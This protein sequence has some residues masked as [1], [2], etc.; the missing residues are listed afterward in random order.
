MWTQA[1]GPTTILLT[2]DNQIFVKNFP[3]FIAKPDP[4]QPPFQGQDWQGDWSKDGSNYTLHISFNGEDKYLSGTTD[5]LRLSL[6]DGR[7]LLIFDRPPQQ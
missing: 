5:G 4:N 3:K 6:K 7:T 1:Y 2:G